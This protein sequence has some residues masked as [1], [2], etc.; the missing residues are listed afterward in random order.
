M[1]LLQLKLV[2]SCLH[3]V[4]HLFSSWPQSPP[5]PIVSQHTKRKK[6][7]GLYCQF[8]LRIENQNLQKIHGCIMFCSSTDGHEKAEFLDTRF[9]SLVSITLNLL[10]LFYHHELG[11]GSQHNSPCLLKI[12]PI[13]PILGAA[14]S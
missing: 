10:W 6:E 13:L 8:F 12:S 1:I 4:S 14:S 11:M 5:F 9:T 7:A 3:L 2:I